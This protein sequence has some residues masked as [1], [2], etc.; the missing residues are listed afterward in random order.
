MKRRSQHRGARA[1]IGQSLAAGHTLGFVRHPDHLDG[2]PGPHQ[3]PDDFPSNIVSIGPPFLQA[4]TVF[5]IVE[6]DPG[7]LRRTHLAKCAHFAA[8]VAPMKMQ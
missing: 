4:I 7:A 2:Y 5:H 1:P 3:S 8:F 6:Q